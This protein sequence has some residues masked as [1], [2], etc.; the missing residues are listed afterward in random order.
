[1]ILVGVAD[2]F[3][4]SQEYP[5]DIYILWENSGDLGNIYILWENPGVPGRY[6]HFLECKMSLELK[7]VLLM[8]EIL[9]N[10]LYATMT[11]GYHNQSLCCH[12]PSWPI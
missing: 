7:P 6:L 12:H 4:T 2:G 9:S 8:W 1:V 11:G 5:G 10:S 3:E